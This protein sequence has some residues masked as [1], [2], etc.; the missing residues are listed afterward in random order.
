MRLE[1]LQRTIQFSKDL[2][3]ST[4]FEYD[5]DFYRVDSDLMGPFREAHTTDT[6]YHIKINNTIIPYSYF[7][8]KRFYI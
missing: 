4:N 2:F 1:S 3:K 5:S 6:R 8:I 7:P